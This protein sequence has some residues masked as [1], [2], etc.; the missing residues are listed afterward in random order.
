MWDL[1]GPG[2]EPMS[3]ALAGGFLPTAPPGKSQCIKILL[4]HVRLYQAH[5][6]IGGK[7]AAMIFH[8]IVERTLNGPRSKKHWFYSQCSTFLQ[9]SHLTLFPNSQI[10]RIRLLVRMSNCRS[11]TERSDLSRTDAGIQCRLKQD[12]QEFGKA[13]SMVYKLSNRKI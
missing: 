8:T 11:C 4:C 9:G 7:A 6:Q 12:S 1:P 5:S 3:P 2:I 13:G 10:K